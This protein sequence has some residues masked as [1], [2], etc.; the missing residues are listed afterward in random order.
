[1]SGV[2]YTPLIQIHVSRRSSICLCPQSTQSKTNPTNICVFRLSRR[3]SVDWRRSIGVVVNW[4]ISGRKYYNAWCIASSGIPMSNQ[5]TTKCDDDRMAL[6]VFVV[7]HNDGSL[8][9]QNFRD[10]VITIINW[11]KEK[12]G[13]HDKSIWEDIV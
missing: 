12:E 7:R 4:S 11:R 6:V 10:H 5:I 2:I 1:M 13:Y 8:Q 3:K 9:P